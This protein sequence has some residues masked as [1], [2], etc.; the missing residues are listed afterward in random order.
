MRRRARRSALLWRTA[1]WSY[2]A[3]ICILYYVCECF[4]L[5]C[6]CTSHHRRPLTYR[7]SLNI[8]F[9]FML[10]HHACNWL[11]IVCLCACRPC[12]FTIRLYSTLGEESTVEPAG[13]RPNRLQ[14]YY[15]YVY[16]ISMRCTSYMIMN[17]K[18]KEPHKNA[19][20]DRASVSISFANHELEK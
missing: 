15:T 18:R 17:D 5:Q 10:S 4:V 14:L 3:A 7:C 20:C 9:Y 8:S 1:C 11:C 12:I 13:A 19:H 2:A 16:R 6:A